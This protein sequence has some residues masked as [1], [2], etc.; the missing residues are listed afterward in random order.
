MICVC[1]GDVVFPPREM[2]YGVSPFSA[3]CLARSFCVTPGPLLLKLAL[4]GLSCP[5]S[6]LSALAL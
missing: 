3:D 5:L 1:L 4:P 2:I 6:C